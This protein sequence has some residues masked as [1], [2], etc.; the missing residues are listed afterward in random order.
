MYNFYFVM[1]KH[2]SSN[3]HTTRHVNWRSRW[4]IVFCEFIVLIS[5]LRFGGRGQ[6]QKP[7]RLQPFRVKTLWWLTVF[8]KFPGHQPPLL[9]F[10]SVSWAFFYILTF[11]T[12]L[13][14]M[15]GTTYIYPFHFDVSLVTTFFLVEVTEKLKYN[16]PRFFIQLLQIFSINYENSFKDGI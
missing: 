1:K 12:I 15:T 2:Y 16:R 13:D 10:L 3:Q 9:T 5:R 11:F 6:L 8:G 14:W 4:K 7:T